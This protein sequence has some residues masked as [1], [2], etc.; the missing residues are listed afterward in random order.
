MG[1]DKTTDMGSGWSP[2]NHK[3]ACL[4]TFKQRYGHLFDFT[5]C[6]FISRTRTSSHCLVPILRRHFVGINLWERRRRAEQ[7]L[8]QNSLNPLCLKLLWSRSN[9]TAIPLT[10]FL[11]LMVVAVIFTVSWHTGQEGFYQGTDGIENC[12]V[13]RQAELTGEFVPWEQQR[14]QQRVIRIGICGQERANNWYIFL[15]LLSLFLSCR[16]SCTTSS[17]YLC[18]RE[19]TARVAIVLVVL[20]GQ[21]ASWQLLLVNIVVTVVDKQQV[22][23]SKQKIVV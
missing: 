7:K 21:L 15:S 17:F 14:E 10:P 6:T 8:M 11:H 20:V 23:T 3:A 19:N 22:T 18:E 2:D 9:Q 1:I 13:S 12:G 5:Q 16:S 4:K